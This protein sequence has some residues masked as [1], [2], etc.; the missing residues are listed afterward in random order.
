VLGVYWRPAP[1]FWYLKPMRRLTFYIMQQIIGPF[2]LFT[3][4]LTSVVWLTQALGMLD[5]VI[6]RGQSAVIFVQLTGL[7]IPTLLVIILPISFFAAALYALHKLN[8]DSELVVM[9]AAGVSRFQLA[10][11]VLL[12][13]LG[14][15]LLTYACGLYFMPAGQRALREKV[16]EIRADIGAAILQE[17]AFTAPSAGLTVFIRE[18]GT[19]GQIHGILVHDSR[20]AQQPITYLAESGIVAQTPE[21]ARLIMENGNIQRSNDSGARLSMLRF[22]RYVFNL[23]QFAGPPSA[24]EREASERYISE[25]FYPETSGAGQETRRNLYWAEG[26]DRLSSPLYC[27]AFA[28]IAL[29]ATAT[30]HLGRSSYAMRITGGAILAAALRMIGFGAQGIAA[31]NPAVNVV[32]YLLPLTGIVLG[33]L[34]VAGVPLVPE[35]VKRIFTQ[36]EAELA[37]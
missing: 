15:M 6:S 5:L 11:P 18:L 22:D 10:T 4:L 21:G 2:A 12:T 34:L 31:R 27:I 25:L 1:H 33:A 3:L 36:S 8:N 23:D 32:L 14:V 19:G 9:W 30:G 28:L 13:A 26:H 29:A 20:N 7:I 16:F 17:G 37:E 35:R 24:T